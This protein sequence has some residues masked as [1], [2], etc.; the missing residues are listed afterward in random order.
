[1]SALIFY[2]TNIFRDYFPKIKYS[3]LYR[4]EFTNN[5]EAHVPHVQA[6][7]ILISIPLYTFSVALRY[8]IL[9]RGGNNACLWYSKPK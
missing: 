2:I 5:L 4:R 9:V 7:Y 1:M 8:M 6:A 3:Y